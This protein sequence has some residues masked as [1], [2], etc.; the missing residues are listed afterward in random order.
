MGKIT[1]YFYADEGCPW[2]KKKSDDLLGKRKGPEVIL[3]S[4]EKS[5]RAR[6]TLVIERKKEETTDGGGRIN[7]GAGS[8]RLS[9]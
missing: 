4:G 2:E 6:L 3:G 5:V 8:S 1:T 7:V 9:L